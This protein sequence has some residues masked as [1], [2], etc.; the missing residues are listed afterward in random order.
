MAAAGLADTRRGWHPVPFA[1]SLDVAW[2][3][4]RDPVDL[5]LMD[6]QMPEMN[7][8]DATRAIRAAGE[9]APRR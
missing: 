4:M 5:E 2:G 3:A 9:A 7:A 8:F 1:R 6:C